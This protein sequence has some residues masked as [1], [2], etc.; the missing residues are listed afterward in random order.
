MTLAT[1]RS[2]GPLTGAPSPLEQAPGPCASATRPAHRGFGDEERMRATFQRHLAI[3][4]R[5]YRKRFSR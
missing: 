4:P 5:D 2:G 3:S 1:D